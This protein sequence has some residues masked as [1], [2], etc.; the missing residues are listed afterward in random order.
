M[1]QKLVAIALVASDVLAKMIGAVGKASTKLTQQI[2]DAAVQC[3]AQSIVHRNAT[4]AAQLFEALSGS[5]RRD[6]LVAYFEQF[7]NLTWSKAE[8]RVIFVD[9]EKLSNGKVKLEWTPEYSAKVAEALWFKAKPEV[10]PK[11]VLD[12]DEE[13][14]KFLERMTKQ[15]KKVGEVK[16]SGLLTV[17]TQAYQKWVGEE[18][19]RKTTAAPT[20]ADI[21]AAKTPAEKAQLEALA[22]KFGGMPQK[23]AA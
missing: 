8:K 5:H 3:V 15:A 20:Q 19:L 17:L 1:T 7:G 16:G 23:V 4:P 14:S 22:A 9:M 21:D 6:A 11:S 13:A 2:Q 18:Y 12:I 10:E